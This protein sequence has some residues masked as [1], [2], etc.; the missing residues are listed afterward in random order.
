M[1][2]L[3]EPFMQEASVGRSR[4]S[5]LRRA[6][7]R[8]I[9]WGL[10]GC[11]FA[12]GLSGVGFFQSSSFRTY[13]STV[14]DPISLQ[15]FETVFSTGTK[16]FFENA[17]LLFDCD[18]TVRDVSLLLHPGRF[19]PTPWPRV[20]SSGIPEAELPP[21]IRPLLRLHGQVSDGIGGPQKPIYV[22]DGL[23]LP[24][25]WRGQWGTVV[26]RT[27]WTPAGPQF[28]ASPKNLAKPW[29][30]IKWN[31]NWYRLGVHSLTLVGLCCLVSI[32]AHLLRRLCRERRSQCWNCGY[33]TVA[34]KR[35]CPECGCIVQHLKSSI[36]DS[37]TSSG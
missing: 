15:Q 20:G 30:P 13:R 23:V 5:A 10:V 14:Q 9:W 24:V 34:S 25:G 12:L 37:Y 6:V 26:F 8:G 31:L 36:V 28:N 35:E 18:A 19:A 4:A 17:P 3:S 33:P 2:C 1:C 21:S 7:A 16:D 29:W 22:F 32:G 27:A 11:A